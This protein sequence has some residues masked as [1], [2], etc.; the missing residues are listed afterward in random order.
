M[1]W[2]VILKYVF[3]MIRMNCKYITITATFMMS[4][5]KESFGCVVS[6]ANP[7]SWEVPHRGAELLQIQFFLSYD[8]SILFYFEIL[9]PLM[10]FIL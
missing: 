6:V 2:V 7:L 10:S 4:Y 1:L 9:Q 3:Y 8:L 5:N